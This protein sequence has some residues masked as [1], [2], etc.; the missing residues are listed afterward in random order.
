M[1]ESR[2]AVVGHCAAGKSTVVALLRE[3]GYDAYSVAQE[4]SVIRDLWRHQDPSHVLYLDVSLE[5]L[6]RRRGNPDWPEWIFEKQ[7]ARLLEARAN[8]SLV[9]DTDRHDPEDVVRIWSQFMGK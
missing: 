3:R 6:R 4:H 9:V 5:E 2:I 1:N 8:A 7:E